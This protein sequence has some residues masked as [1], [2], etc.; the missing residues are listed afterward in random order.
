MESV[1]RGV[2]KKEHCTIET[3]YGNV[4]SSKKSAGNE[5]AVRFD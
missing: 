4:F 3:V 2:S 5:I 1:Q